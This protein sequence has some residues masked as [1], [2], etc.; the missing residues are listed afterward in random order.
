MYFD[1]CLLF[2]EEEDQVCIILLR[3]W[4]IVEFVSFLVHMGRKKIGLAWMDEESEY[5]VGIV[6][7]NCYN[8]N[9]F[10]VVI[11]KVNCTCPN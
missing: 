10:F 7:K 6:A 2:R 3:K 1:L 9:L 11:P 4:K 5:I 8:T